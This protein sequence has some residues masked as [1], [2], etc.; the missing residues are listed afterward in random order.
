MYSKAYVLLIY[1]SWSYSFLNKQKNGQSVFW[2]FSFISVSQLQILNEV[3]Q[4]LQQRALN[5]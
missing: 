3:Q 4:L 2:N 5:L 1:F